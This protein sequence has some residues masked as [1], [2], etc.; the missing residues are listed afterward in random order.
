[1]LATHQIHPLPLANWDI[2]VN[3]KIG[4]DAFASEGLPQ[5][6]MLLLPSDFSPSHF[7]VVVGTGRE[8][9]QHCGNKAFQRILQRDYLKIYSKA[10]TKLEKTMI[11]S[12]I[13]ATIRER[14]PAKAGFV[15]R[16]NETWYQVE[17]TIARE[18]I[19]QS[20]RNLLHEQYRS[21]VKAKRERRSL[22]RKDMDNSIDALMN[23]SRSFLSR[24]FLQLSSD[25]EATGGA[26]ASDHD[27]LELFS[28]ANSDILEG[29]KRERTMIQQEK[30]ASLGYLLLSPWLCWSSNSLGKLTK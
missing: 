6:D 1:M 13:V 4:N 29:L 24:R 18:K 25:I 16:I 19:S 30:L 2:A 8:A 10:E 17:D 26:K 14:S 12:E 3:E 15:K 21:S 9:K 23:S 20:L 7:D 5:H 27:I 11:I 28:Q 22:I